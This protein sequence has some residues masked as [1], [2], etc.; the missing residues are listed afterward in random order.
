MPVLSGRRVRGPATRRQPPSAAPLLHPR[1]DP[2]QVPQSR[3]L[4]FAPASKPGSDSEPAELPPCP[5]PR[6][7]LHSC[8]PAVGFGEGPRAK[9]DG[10]LRTVESNGEIRLEEKPWQQPRI[11]VRSCGSK[12]RLCRDVMEHKRRDAVRVLTPHL[13]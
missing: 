10:N 9:P 6:D 4:A 2:I 13:M 12:P 11:D 5:R 1:P 3:G 7:S 8:P